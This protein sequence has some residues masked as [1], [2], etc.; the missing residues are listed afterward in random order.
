MTEELIPKEK[1]TPRFE[2]KKQIIAYVTAAFGLVAGL[3]W[4]DAIRSLI[5]YMFIFEKDSILVKFI[6]TLVMTLVLT[7]ITYYVSRVL[8]RQKE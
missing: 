4:N 5:E 8:K 2:V 6:Y 3:A 7:F 1:Q